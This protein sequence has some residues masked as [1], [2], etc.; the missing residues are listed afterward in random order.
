MS[1][2]R[3]TG[4]NPLW[5]FLFYMKTATKSQ[6]IEEK[7]K[8][9]FDLDRK[10][11]D[12]DQIIFTFSKNRVVFLLIALDFFVKIWYNLLKFLRKS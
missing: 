9:K 6:G 8:I 7:S 2:A 5:L 1:E 4:G 3:A 10:G 11:I 12:L